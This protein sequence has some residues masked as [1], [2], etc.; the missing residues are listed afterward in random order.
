MESQTELQIEI[1]DKRV[2]KSRTKKSR[3]QMTKTEKAKLWEIL[4]MDTTKKKINKIF[5]IKLRIIYI[6]A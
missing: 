1:D 2:A 4:D 5:L 3:V 6:I